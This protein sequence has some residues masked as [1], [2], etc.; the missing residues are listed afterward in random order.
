MRPSS[1][2]QPPGRPPRTGADRGTTAGARRPPRRLPLRVVE[3]PP[4]ADAPGPD[5]GAADDPVRH[6]HWRQVGS[7]LTVIVLLL[8]LVECVV[9]VRSMDFGGSD[10]DAAPAAPVALS[11]PD[12]LPDRG[13]LV[14]S[15]VRADGSIAV[16][17]WI[18]GA[19]DID[20]ISLAAPPV[21]GG[22]GTFRAVN[23]RLVAADGTVLAAH[24]TV[25]AE[26]RRIRFD[27][28]T[29]LLR[30]TYVLRGAVDRSSTVDGRIR[31]LTVSL[32]VDAAAE[33][34]P[35]VLVVNAVPGAGE[36]LNLACA[37]ARSG[38]ALLR[39]CGSPDGAGWR[40]RLPAGSRE[41]RV[42]A[43]LDVP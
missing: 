21:V 32:D 38:A 19:G 15:E 8:L 42:V 16:T 13:A 14:R 43:Q 35:T 31:A 26:P 30:A 6:P 27:A 9:V 24:L 7:V 4:T 36:V 11:P 34:G 40:V 10:P 17:H 28:P 29:R 2:A 18:R 12:A 25:G 23:G 41:D 22:D 1:R 3:T 37:N 20:E 5:A 33:A 39:P